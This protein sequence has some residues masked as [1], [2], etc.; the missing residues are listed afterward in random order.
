MIIIT[1]LNLRIQNKTSILTEECTTMCFLLG[2]HSFRFGVVVQVCLFPFRLGKSFLWL[3]STVNDSV[4]NFSLFPSIIVWSEQPAEHQLTIVVTMVPSHSRV[5]SPLSLLL[6]LSL[7]FLVFPHIYHLTWWRPPFTRDE[8]SKLFRK[9]R[10]PETPQ[11]K[12][13]RHHLPKNSIQIFMMIILSVATTRLA[14]V[15]VYISTIVNY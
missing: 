7:L 2:H 8:P 6:I 13:S 5:S 14:L 3:F 4:E 9:K 1:M 11:E 10:M 12:K 15:V